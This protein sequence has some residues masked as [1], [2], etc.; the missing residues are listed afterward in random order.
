MKDILLQKI[1]RVME[2][3]ADRLLHLPPSKNGK[4]FEAEDGVFELSHIYSTNQAFITGMV[5]R[6]YAE[7]KDEKYLKWCEKFYDEY[8][9]KVSNQKYDT[10]QNTGM[11]Y[12]LYAVGMYKLNND[13]KYKRTALLA[14]D[15][16]ARRFV[17]KNGYLKA[18][19]RGDSHFPSYVDSWSEDNPFYSE[20]KGLMVIETM[21]NLPLLFWAYKVSKHPFYLWIALS[22]IDATKKYLIRRDNTTAHG[23]RFNEW[24][25]EVY[26]ED[27]YF[28]YSK[29][30]YWA[31]GAAMGIYGFAIAGRYSG[32]MIPVAVSLLDRFIDSCDGK[33]PVWDFTAPDKTVDTTAAAIVLCAVRE[34][35]RYTENEK[36]NCFEKTIEKGLSEY[37]DKNM[38]IDGILKEQN[39][40]H[41]YDLTGDYFLT[42]AY[43]GG[44]F[45]VW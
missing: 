14:A 2:K 26:C 34:I 4:Y 28:G 36:I 32:G 37:V 10:S 19:G 5:L 30:S 9:E 16:V 27:N 20:N 18:W 8:H 13:E 21:M 38:D 25:G 24:T 3:S 43:L 22:H 35:K 33:M 17:P 6:A 11:L 40:R 39:G 45:S 23:Y 41:E 31:K 42:E 44:D 7:T 29:G 15:E 12:S 1:D